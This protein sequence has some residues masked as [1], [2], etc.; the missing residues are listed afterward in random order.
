MCAEQIVH[1]LRLVLICAR[2]WDNY[3]LKVFVGATLNRHA[4]V[5]EEEV[6]DFHYLYIYRI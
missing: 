4:L 6:Y 5:M 1:V 3:R 2:H